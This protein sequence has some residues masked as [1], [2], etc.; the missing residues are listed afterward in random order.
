MPVCTSL[1]IMSIIP[2]VTI[3]LKECRD[4]QLRCGSMDHN[5]AGDT[6][7]FPIVELNADSDTENVISERLVN[8]VAFASLF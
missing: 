8:C 1:N 7:S 4:V 3:L 5:Y 6:I 2:Q